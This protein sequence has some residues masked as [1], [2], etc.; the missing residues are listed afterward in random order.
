VEK[1][2]GKVNGKHGM[3]YF[4]HY[5]Q[6]IGLSIREYGEFSE[7]EFSIM[8]KFI[9]NGDVVFDIGANIGAFTIPFAKKVGDDGKIYSFEPQSFIYDL[10]CRNI[11]ENNLKNIRNFNNGLG[12]SRQKI[13]LDKIDYSS[14]GNF[15]GVGLK[16][17]YDNTAT[18][19][20]LKNEKKQIVEIIKLDDF[21]N[22][23]KCDFVKMDVEMMEIDVLEGGK[24]FIE[25]YRPVMWLE[26]HIIYPNQINDYL[27]KLNY[28]VFWAMTQLYNPENYF[29]NNKNYFDDTATI[30]SLAVPREKASNHDTK[31]LENIDSS[32]KI[33]HTRTL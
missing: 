23:K 26:N 2:V 30:N 28:D 20:I 29:A 12:E 15:G 4:C 9:G 25:K 7:I 24:R 13:K 32:P 27:S 33:L 8:Q 6:Y 11:K 21:L 17:D 14:V 31:W 22:I 19:K 10:L 16:D 5:D 1:F 18:A 3:F